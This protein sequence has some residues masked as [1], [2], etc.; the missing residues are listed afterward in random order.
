MITSVKEISYKFLKG[1]KII[2]G[3]SII[4][5]FIS[6]LLII[7]MF[8]FSDKSIKKFK[9][10]M[11]NKYGIEYKLLENEKSLDNEVNNEIERINEAQLSLEIYIAFLGILILMIS[12]LF[13]NSNMQNFFYKY[14]K[15]LEILRSFGLGSK[16]SFKILLFQNTTINFIGIIL[17]L[18]GSCF[19]K[20]LNWYSVLIGIIIFI[21]LEA[22]TIIIPIR[23]LK[24]LPFKK[25]EQNT[26]YRLKR[27]RK[28]TRN[29]ILLGI[30]GI[31]LVL[32]IILDKKSSEAFI[33]MFVGGLIILISFIMIL[34]SILNSFIKKVLTKIGNIIASPRRNYL[35]ILII[36]ISMIICVLGSDFLF[37][38][39]K[40][41]REY[42]KKLYPKD[43]TVKMNLLKND[44][45]EE[46]YEKI[47]SIKNISC[48]PNYIEQG[49]IEKNNK[50]IDFSIKFDSTVEV[51]EV[52]LLKEIADKYRINKGEVLKL[53]KNILGNKEKTILDEEEI[54]N[55]KVK[56]ITEDL[57]GHSFYYDA[58]MN[59]GLLNWI[60]EYKNLINVYIETD[61]IEGT[62]LELKKIQ[63]EYPEISYGIYEEELKRDSEELE[64]RWEMFKI[65]IISITISTMIGVCNMVIDYIYSRKE[66]IEILRKLGV[67]KKRVIF[68]IG[69]MLLVYFIIGGT[70]GFI[71]G[72]TMNFLLIIVG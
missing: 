35:C 69:E 11:Q 44:E 7:G 28:R 51:G 10:E 32:L 72:K 63:K 18:I 47:K 17:G 26:T 42:L 70:F 56:D 15:Q 46:A 66:E 25:D 41:N 57:E 49:S 38:V 2:F 13:I 19:F 22:F 64:K 45:I 55:V 5:I 37:I 43:I 8:E 16:E 6:T 40:N 24:I 48:I 9:G 3:S 30:S 34:P 12:S 23:G 21:L 31:I 20:M 54:K 1:N 33:G 71:I 61:D 39:N 52:V 68:S 36:T 58:V 65:A 62:K 14:K 67:T 27:M 50:I 59:I 60:S 4:A 53:R 29:G